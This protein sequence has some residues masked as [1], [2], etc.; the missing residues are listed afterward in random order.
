MYFF[1]Y[2]FIFIYLF[3]YLFVSSRLFCLLDVEKLE[4]PF[5]NKAPYK[6]WMTLTIVLTLKKATAE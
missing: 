1:V 2:L 6:K 3:I 5:V 4:T